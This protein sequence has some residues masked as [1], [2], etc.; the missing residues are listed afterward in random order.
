[1]K[2]RGRSEEDIQSATLLRGLLELCIFP[3]VRRLLPL[4]R[5]RVSGFFLILLHVI[6]VQC[7]QGRESVASLMP[8][9]CTEE[10]RM[11]TLAKRD[12][13]GKG[14]ESLMALRLLR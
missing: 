10:E 4:P 13:H 1:M 5:D 14:M 9:H 6:L 3:T 8:G 2:Q 11:R 7:S 12:S